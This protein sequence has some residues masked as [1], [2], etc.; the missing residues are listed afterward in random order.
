MKLKF[1]CVLGMFFVLPILTINAHAQN[2]QELMIELHKTKT[3]SFKAVYQQSKELMDYTIADKLKK[4]GIAKGKKQRGFI[5]YAG[6]VLPQ[7][8]PN[9]L[10]VY[11]KVEA[12]GN[13][14]AIYLLLATGYDNFISSSTDATIANNAIAFLNQLVEDAVLMKKNLEIGKQTAVV[15]AL[16]EQLAKA[17]AKKEKRFKK[18]RS[19]QKE[20]ENVTREQEKITQQLIA[21]KDRLASLNSLLTP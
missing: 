12:Q 10:D 21:E 19:L 8:S 9:K 3:N 13:N 16:S 1:A 4:A 20:Y 17:E 14:A 2:A 6:V 5:Q 18:L 15:Q 11:I 7:L